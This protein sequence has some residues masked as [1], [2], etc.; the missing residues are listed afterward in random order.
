M[1]MAT[2]LTTGDFIETL[3]RNTG[4]LLVMFWERRDDM[5][6][7]MTRSAESFVEQSDGRVGLATVDAKANPDLTCR[8]RIRSFPTMLVFRK[9]ERVN[10]LTGGITEVELARELDSLVA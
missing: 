9:A 3:M 5:T 2:E 10:S 8:Y 4:L 6:R 1:P 7:I